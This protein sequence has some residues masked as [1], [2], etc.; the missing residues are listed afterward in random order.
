VARE[1][2]AFG[3]TKELLTTLDEVSQR[4]GVSRGQAFE[5]FLHMSV[6]ALSGGVIEDEYLQVVQKHS[7][8][9]HGRRGCDVIAKLFGQVVSVMEETRQDV[10]G[11]LFQ[12]A[13]TYGEAGQF[14]TPEAVCS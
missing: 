14:L 5:D 7:T 13:I 6:C 10:L 3:S 2:F 8:G 9:M 12:G 1:Q 11:D 4:S